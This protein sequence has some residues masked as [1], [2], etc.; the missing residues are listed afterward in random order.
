MKYLL[1]VC[2]LGMLNC[3]QKNP[4]SAEQ[5][6]ETENTLT[7]ENLKT[8]IL[9]P[10]ILDEVSGIALSEDRKL[11]YAI[12]DQGNPNVVYTVD[13]KGRIIGETAVQNVENN[14]WEDITTDK[15]GFTYIGNF[16]NNEND[17][18]DLSILKVDVRSGDSE[19]NVLQETK[20]SYPEQTE[21]PPKKSNLMFDCEGFVVY[22]GNFYLFTKNRSKNFDG[23]F[24][25]YKVPNQSGKVEAQLV[26]KLKIEG[27]Y[28]DAA[29][30]SAAINSAENQIVLLTH[31]NIHILK[32]FS[33]DDFGKATVETKSLNHN[34]QKEAVVFRDDKILLIADEAEKKNTAKVYS[35]SLN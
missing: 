6:K 32:N 1:A 16:G 20:F 33:L 17:R 27:A 30:T 14:D 5:S 23:S 21:F 7:A 25:V 29:I 24:Y 34:S 26:G 12:A 31:K 15:N 2:L 4:D 3:Q 18:Q 10:K 13:F 35:F 19:A 11:I 8:E 9:L 28:S 22:N